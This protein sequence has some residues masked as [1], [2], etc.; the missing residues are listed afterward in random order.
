MR[1]Q[2]VDLQRGGGRRHQKFLCIHKLLFVIAMMRRI[3]I[4]II[5]RMVMI[6]RMVLAMIIIMS[7]LIKLLDRKPLEC[8]E[9]PAGNW[10]KG[11]VG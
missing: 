4:L 1:K 11:K 8:I 2:R 9:A 3:L 10:L 6:K 7:I 5:M